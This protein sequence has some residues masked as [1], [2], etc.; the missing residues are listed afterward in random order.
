MMPYFLKNDFATLC[1]D[2]AGYKQGCHSYV[3]ALKDW[4]GLDVV[5]SYRDVCFISYF[6][7]LVAFWPLQNCD[8]LSLQV[9]PLFFV[10]EGIGANLRASRRQSSF[11]LAIRRID[12]SFFVVSRFT[13]QKVSW[14]VGSSQVSLWDLSVWIWFNLGTLWS[15]S[16]HFT[17]LDLCFMISS[18][19]LDVSVFHDI[20]WLLTRLQSSFQCFVISSRRHWQAAC[21]SLRR[22]WASQKLGHYKML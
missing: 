19:F 11:R 20:S 9:L 1:L 18:W 13:S 8:E 17:C 14:T 4:I 6:V 5:S 12:V 22:S 16:E 21:K 7:I 2:F 3:E 15:A 10:S